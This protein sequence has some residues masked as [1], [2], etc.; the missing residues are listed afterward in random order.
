MTYEIPEP[1][2][3]QKDEGYQ[4]CSECLDG[5]HLK[6]GGFDVPRHYI[7]QKCGMSVVSKEEFFNIN[8]IV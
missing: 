4:E 2:E 8:Y 7:C 5:V 6:N 3:S 1:T